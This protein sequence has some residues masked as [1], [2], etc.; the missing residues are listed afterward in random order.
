MN[1]LFNNDR[2]R[3][4]TYVGD[5]HQCCRCQI[6]RLV[7]SPFVGTFCDCSCPSLCMST[8]SSFCTLLFFLGNTL[9]LLGLFLF[10]SL[11]ILEPLL[12]IPFGCRCRVPFLSP[13]QHTCLTFVTFRLIKIPQECQ[14]LIPM[15]VRGELFDRH[16]HIWM[17]EC[18]AGVLNTVSGRK[19]VKINGLGVYALRNVLNLKFSRVVLAFSRCFPVRRV[20]GFGWT[21]VFR[22]P[23]ASADFEG[24][25]CALPGKGLVE[26]GVDGRT[27]RLGVLRA[28][29]SV[30]SGTFR[31]WHSRHL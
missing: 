19:E 1:M 25:A 5:R 22:L 21:R 20:G 7:P 17:L 29:I 9:S 6:E 26:I 8:V 23:F 30:D 3:K 27:L 13:L 4:R 15:L 31:S 28:G 16:L 10:I 2:K 14:N 12:S 11:Q 24:E 18:A